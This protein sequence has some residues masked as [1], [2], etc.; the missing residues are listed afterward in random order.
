MV[1][2][3]QGGR[4]A[5]RWGGWLAL[6]ALAGALAFFAASLRHPPVYRAEATVAVVSAVTGNEADLYDVDLASALI[7]TDRLT[8]QSRAVL[9]DVIATLHLPTTPAALGQQITVV[10]VPGTNLLTIQVYYENSGDMA[11]RLANTVAAQFIRRATLDRAAPLAA[12]QAALAARQAANEADLHTALTRQATLRAAPPRSPAAQRELEGLDATIAGYLLT[13]STL[14]QQ[15]D[16]LGQI[17]AF[18][19]VPARLVEQAVPPEP[20]AVRGVGS[21]GVVALTGALAA[22]L[23]L[24]A[25]TFAAGTLREA[26]EV[27]AALRLPVLGAIPRD[28]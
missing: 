3:R 21:L 22:A 9:S 8:I 12:Q 6:G 26:E 27:R 7:E 11:A 24:W 1:D 13:R 2:L 15:R 17:Q 4:L 14:R 18:N 25:L 20:I 28:K 19:A 16:A 10:P 23:V 5:R